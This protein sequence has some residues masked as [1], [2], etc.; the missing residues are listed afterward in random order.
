M[1]SLSMRTRSPP[2][3][4]SPQ[5]TALEKSKDPGPRC[6]TLTGRLFICLGSSPWNSSPTTTIT[7]LGKGSSWARVARQRF[8]IDVSAPGREWPALGMMIEVLACEIGWGSTMELGR[9][10]RGAG[11]AYS[12]R[13]AASIR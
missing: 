5:L 11:R 12:R 7:S 6:K 3:A 1:S 4:N 8:S 2:L 9:C 13:K 10:Y